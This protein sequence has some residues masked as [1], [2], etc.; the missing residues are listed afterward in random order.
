MAPAPP[1]DLQI[2]G[3]VTPSAK[4]SWIAPDDPE[5]AGFEVLWRE[6]TNPRWSVFGFAKSSGEFVFKN[7]STDNHFFAVRSVGKNGA[8][9][10]A[11]PAVA[12]MP[13]KR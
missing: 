6:T 9:S 4:I 1:T 11:V 3:A 8:R 13:R 5:R 2:G 12:L 7:V 10:I